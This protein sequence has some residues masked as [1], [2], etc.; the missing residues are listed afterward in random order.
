MIQ[1]SRYFTGENVRGQFPYNQQP[2][3]GGLTSTDKN[4]AQIAAIIWF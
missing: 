3:A 4:A 2:G 1:Y